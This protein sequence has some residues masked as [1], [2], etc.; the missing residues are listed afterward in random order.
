MSYS[1]GAHISFSKT[2]PFVR[3]GKLRNVGER[4]V[5]T[6]G[7]FSKPEPVFNVPVRVVLA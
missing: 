5:F 6:R 3:I 7:Q 1:I 2:P 4:V